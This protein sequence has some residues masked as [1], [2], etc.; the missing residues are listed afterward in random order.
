[1]SG[2]KKIFKHAI[3]NIALIFLSLI[4]IFIMG[5][6]TLRSY[7]YYK[8]RISILNDA[9]H[10]L[11]SKDDKLGW[12]MSKNL[13]YNVKDKDALNNIREQYIQTKRRIS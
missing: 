11:L 8:Y 7:H 13:K 2:I 6:M 10:G 5:E 12:K 3:N 4:I 9:N 1:M